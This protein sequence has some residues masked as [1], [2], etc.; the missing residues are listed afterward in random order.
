M[1]FPA[2]CAGEGRR[3]LVR[4]RIE[5][6]NHGS[7]V[8]LDTVII[9]EFSEPL[10]G[11]TVSAD[12]VRLLCVETGDG[13]RE[14]GVETPVMGR[15]SLANDNTVL[16]FTPELPLAPNALY[17][18]QLS[19]DITDRFGYALVPDPRT[20]NREPPTG[21]ESTFTT[22][23]VFGADA[24]PPNTLRVSLPE[25][26]GQPVPLG[27]IGEVLVCGG[28]NLAV[29]G[30]RVEVFVRSGPH[31]NNTGSPACATPFEGQVNV[32]PICNPPF[33]PCTTGQL[34]R[35]P[36][37]T[38]GSFCTVVS[39]VMAGDRIA[40]R[41]E[42]GLGNIV[43][44]DAGNMRDF[45]TGAEI[46][47][48]EG[49]TVTFIADE[50]YAAIIPEGAFPEPT[51][52]QITALAAEE[53]PTPSDDALELVGAVRLDFEGI[54]ERNIDIS[55]PALDGATTDDQY[56]ATKV[57]NVRGFDEH[58]MVD[59]ASFDPETGLVVTGDR[60]DLELIY[61]A[62]NFAV[63]LVNDCR[64]YITGFALRGNII[65][66]MLV[67]SS[68]ANALIAA[69]QDG[70]GT[71]PENKFCLPL[72]CNE[73][74]TIELVLD[75]TMLA[76]V[77]VDVPGRAVFKALHAPLQDVS[78]YE[79]KT[80]RVLDLSLLPP[81]EGNMDDP[82][83][84]LQVV[85]DEPLVGPGSL[86][87]QDSQGHT[88]TGELTLSVDGRVLTFTPKTRLKYGETYTVTLSGLVDKE[89][90]PRPLPPLPPEQSTFHTFTPEIRG[91]IGGVDA[92]DVAVIEPV[93]VGL[94]EDRRLIAVADGRGGA[95]SGSEPPSG[96]RVYD[97]SDLPL[98]GSVDLTEQ[99]T[100]Q[101]A[102]TAG[103][104]YALA[105]VDGPPITV[106][107]GVSPSNPDG[108]A[109]TF[110]GP[111]LLSV[112]GAGDDT[113]F[114]LLHL[115]TL[116]NF[117]QVEEIAVRYLNHSGESYKLFNK[118]LRNPIGDPPAFLKF[119]D[120]QYGL[121]L[122]VAA[123]NADGA[124]V[125]YV[126][127]A[128]LIGL[129]MVILDQL[130]VSQFVPQVDERFS[131]GYRS[132]TT[133]RNHV[134]AV[135]ND[136]AKLV[137]L[138]PFLAT[139]EH[140]F[141]LGGYGQ[142]RAVIALK[143]WPSRVV[144]DGIQTLEPRDLAVALDGGLNIAVVP[145]DAA[146]GKFNEGMLPQGAGRIATQAG[147]LN[148]AAGDRDAQILYAAE[149]TAGLGLID[150]A[151]PSGSVDDDND[152]VD[153]RVL[154]G[155][156]LSGPAM[157][158]VHYRDQCQRPVAAVAAGQ[159]GVD[160]V[161]VAPNTTPR[162][163]YETSVGGRRIVDPRNPTVDARIGLLVG[164]QARFRARLQPDVPLTDHLY[165]WSGAVSGSGPEKPFQPSA[166]SA[167][168]VGL[169]TPQCTTVEREAELLVVAEPPP[170]TF[171]GFF[172]DDPGAWTVSGS[173]GFQI[174][175]VQL[176][177]SFVSALGGGKRNGRADAW[178]H[179]VWN[180]RVALQVG[181]VRARAAATAH[182]RDAY[183]NVQAG[184]IN[185]DAYNE[186]VMDTLNNLTC[187]SHVAEA[188]SATDAEAVAT[189]LLNSGD[190]W[191][192]DDVQNVEWIGLLTPS[193][194]VSP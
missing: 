55:V 7:Q 12:S 103:V 30:T 2:R 118:L 170:P 157:E 139:P 142:A 74:V 113:D 172:L 130:K 128:P 191:I 102:T 76:Q 176:T 43:T 64:G 184:N 146:L 110:D 163:E 112:D 90:P 47:G 187:L 147:I 24:L 131:G 95:S 92:Q 3:L 171:A 50:R 99:I 114:G 71:N 93:A 140:E 94:P 141:P 32:D 175:N 129:Q 81:A 109:I 96:L 28:A 169:R 161:Q 34:G 193:N 122:D 194:A 79:H 78:R 59:I 137:L 189:A 11:N 83:A 155:T 80:P 135:G 37:V 182:E 63:H 58:T 56:L 160:L 26:N 29:P 107:Q 57:I 42:D 51:L 174:E 25:V 120:N 159:G 41:V 149:G 89:N 10:D 84:P 16:L 14:T 69:L 132:V 150:L 35:C 73:E 143:D 116:R 52:V 127:N 20:T 154:G 183:T 153:D 180:L 173:I 21:F 104:D 67:R 108:T 168:T 9:A 45:E 100:A 145:V 121:P 18:F 190:L 53:V 192:L 188:S 166:V 115:Y 164:E 86:V 46:I 87:L 82:L 85:F 39:A 106:R 22:A 66:T 124:Q 138:D 117:P 54:A 44:L 91:H 13:R 152:G 185:E 49:G 165:Q 179:C 178:K 105:F 126:A 148:G 70:L 101:S 151:N 97:V 177:E 156:T 181:E 60:D 75:D 65:G 98:S 68:A 167:Y 48:P 33:S 123:V 4:I 36:L 31:A 19:D 134:L 38:P 158:V 15:V 162:L 111:F 61:A 40:V 62:G 133:L 119:I 1:P 17:R 186:I 23:D 125:A 88:V 5:P 77:S 144:T 136:P 8:P 6:A 27:E 72:L